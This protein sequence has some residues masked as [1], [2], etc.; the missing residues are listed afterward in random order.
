MESMEPPVI[1]QNR[2]G[3]PSRAIGHQDDVERLPA[4]SGH[5]FTGAGEKHD[6]EL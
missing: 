5:F 1:P 4:Q 6:L 2:A 3:S